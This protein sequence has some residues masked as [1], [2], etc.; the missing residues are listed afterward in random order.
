MKPEPQMTQISRISYFG[1]W[2]NNLL[3][4]IV[5]S[6]FTP[7]RYDVALRSNCLLQIIIFLCVG[8]YPAV[9][10]TVN[11]CAEE[12]T[13]PASAK[14]TADEEAKLLLAS[15]VEVVYRWEEPQTSVDEIVYKR[16]VKLRSSKEATY[17][18]TM[19]ARC[20]DDILVSRNASPD[21]SRQKWIPER[22]LL[23][24][25]IITYATYQKIVETMPKGTYRI[26]YYQQTPNGILQLGEE[27][28]GTGEYIPVGEFVLTIASEVGQESPPTLWYVGGAIA[29]GVSVLDYFNEKKEEKNHPP[30]ASLIV[31]PQTGTISNT[32]Y[33]DATASADP[34]ESTANLL[35]RWDWD[36]DGNWD[37]PFSFTKTESRTF[38]LGPHTIAMQLRDSWGL[39]ALTSKSISVIVSGS[40]PAGTAHPMF[41]YDKQHTAAS[42]YAG[43]IINTVKWTCGT[44]APVE[45]SP[46]IAANNNVYVG[47]Y[48][49]NLYCISYTSGSVLWT[50]SLGAAVYSSPAIATDGTIYVGAGNY[51]YA[52]NP[53]STVKWTYDTGAFIRSSPVI[54]TDGTVY[55]GSTNNKL[56]A[57]NHDSSFK[58]SFT[59]GGLI[60]SSPAI[61]ADGTVYIGSGDGKLYAVNPATASAK[62]TYGPT[63]GL[64][65]APSADGAGT[66]YAGSIDG[67]LYALNSNGTL[68]WTFPTGGP[69][70]SSPAIG[71][72]VYI[73]SD[74]G[75]LYSVNAAT[76]A[77]NW[78]YTT[79]NKIRSSP[80]IDSAG[81]IYFGSDDGKIYCLN[82]G[83][84]LVWS[85]DTTQPVR[86]SP[87]IA[88]TPAQVIYIGSNDMN[89][90][91]ICVTPSDPANV[92]ISNRANKKYVTVG[93]VITYSITV[94]NFTSTTDTSNNNI[95]IDRI[96]GGFR[97]LAG[98]TRLDGAAQPNPAITG[99]LL[100]F[101]DIGPI[102]P[103][104]SETLS[105]QLLVGS[106]VRKGAH[107]NTAYCQ[108]FDAAWK[109]SN[110]V[111]AKVL[112]IDDPLFDLGTIIGKVFYD[113]NNDGEPQ[114]IEP[115]VSG[116]QV[117]M[118]DGTIV[119]TDKE[120]RFHIPGIYPGRHLL[121][122]QRYNSRP[123]LVN[124]TEGLLVKANFAVNSLEP[125][126][127]RPVSEP[128][129]FT[130]V[131]L[132]DG[133][134][135]Q[136][137]IRRDV[138]AAPRADRDNDT[139]AEGRIAY[140]IK[141]DIRDKFKITSSFDTLRNP[142]RQGGTIRNQAM[143]YIDPDKYYLTYGDESTVSFDA[144]NTQGPFYLFMES[145]PAAKMG[146]SNLLI[147][148]YATAITGTELAV[149]NRSLYGGK[150]EVKTNKLEVK[151]FGAA[152]HHLPAHNELRATGGSFYYL[153]H[154][155]II[156]GSE[157]VRVET[158]DKITHLTRSSSS[159]TRGADYEIDYSNGRIVFKEPIGSVVSS[160]SIISGNILNGD[161]VYILVDYEYQPDTLDFKDGSAGGRV[162]AT[163][164]KQI[165]IGTTYIHEVQPA[166]DYELN[167][168]DVTL[169]PVWRMVTSVAGAKPEP[170]PLE[171]QRHPALC[172]VEIKTE[173]AR[174]TSRGI[175]GYVSTDGG[176]DFSTIPNT[177]ADAG[178]AFSVRAIYSDICEPIGLQTYYQK[179]LPGFTSDSA[180]FQQGT[181]KYGMETLVKLSGT[182]KLNLRYDAQEVLSDNLNI[183]S[184]SV[185][186]AKKTETTSLQGVYQKDKWTI[187]PE[188]RYQK[189]S[190][191][192][193]AGTDS[194][195]DSSLL[196]LRA[197]YRVT[198]KLKVFAGQQASFSGQVNNQTT[199]GA[200]AVLTDKTAGHLQVTAG[201]K[202]SSML[203]GLSSALSSR[204]TA[205]TNYSIGKTAVSPALIRSQD[206]NQR[207][208]STAVGTTTQVTDA[209]TVST[210]QEYKTTDDSIVL[211]SR[212]SQDTQINSNPDAGKWMLGSSFERGII[213]NF[214]GGAAATS[215]LMRG[216]EADRQACSVNLRYAGRADQP[217][218]LGEL[219]SKI[220]ARFD[221]GIVDNHQYLTANYVKYQL[222]E[223]LGVSGRLNWSTTVNDTTDTREARFQEYGLGAAL[224]PVKWDR[225][226]LIAKYSYLEDVRPISQSDYA[227]VAIRKASIYALET[228]YDISEYL[229]MVE[230]Y[231]RRV[232]DETV[233]VQTHSATS[234][235]LNRLNYRFGALS[236]NAFLKQCSAGL[237][238]RERMVR[239]K[240]Q[241]ES[242]AGDDKTGLLIELNYDTPSNGKTAVSPALMRGNTGVRFGL[243]YNFT[244]FSDEL[245][246]ND[247]STG[248][249]FIRVT[250]T[251]AY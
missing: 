50:R 168:W 93:E 212:L 176:L 185:I 118:E 129:P 230:K 84:G 177:P 48:D 103:G 111:K 44:G 1:S 46:S 19:Y 164:D 216:G 25:N 56:F 120:G 66:V 17:Y 73:G 69:V 148:N 114:M 71:G 41:R 76:G 64:A 81:N 211:L 109:V 97:Y 153:K 182:T 209:T 134:I 191:E 63:G 207:A 67:I 27:R 170:P 128:E 197:D 13:D 10:G 208:A 232:M 7:C 171:P 204:T 227:D 238:Y 221:D 90:Y 26:L 165:T 12:Q 59:T 193:P 160:D 196:A 246:L 189:I 88:Q 203:L 127:I 151:A 226:H 57:I 228:A 3:P 132:A 82:S 40:P 138:A 240:V 218:G 167:G 131:G 136:S 29:G 183:V 35:V 175:P 137:R 143:R 119:T 231:A 234:L 30:T 140:Y 229:Q 224:R 6:N 149:Y 11:I 130:I 18:Y 78:E 154:K 32:F 95:I 101:V 184:T 2:R 116:A 94:G 152:A 98:S 85:R 22:L 53:D 202:G 24:G 205:Y 37:T 217:T 210:Q 83:G 192:T 187:T 249:F 52:L 250:T 150:L 23:G 174:S 195:D 126:N 214:S 61:G 115:G 62:W 92:V 96:P 242:D 74:D 215:R 155:D 186:G 38:T 31:I 247:Y 60:D 39:D 68:K 169:R 58:W 145:L 75:K 86:S 28:I 80:A 107:T 8:V 9:G 49:G 108:F 146:Q 220:E 105:Y 65:G 34:D 124:I 144:T 172:G 89:L 180:Y 43:P 162:T 213:N 45:S 198:D 181:Q 16:L 141:G 239:G 222:T 156:D 139:Y 248:G 157:Q 194:P 233:S 15:T 125:I 173:Y 42:P 123:Q 158:R 142:S 179:F 133:E 110:T 54:D 178:T 91:S 235:W 147:G 104:A 243:G 163:P 122:L 190:V 55:I 245:S 219:R 87:A 106:D 14:A 159:A 188:V 199:A 72:A 51:L 21:T 223:D 102:A 99:T 112:V 244:S 20:K 241:G 225:W 77:K 201:N 33:F 117:I 100:T 121:K 70:Y 237:E 161:P 200:S 236:K 206:N 251:L 47:S 5:G 4:S 135:G 113:V 166:H 79:G 36:N